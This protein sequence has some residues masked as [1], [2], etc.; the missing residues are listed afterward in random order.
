MTKMTKRQN[1]KRQKDKK[2]KTKSDKKRY[3]KTKMQN[4]SKRRKIGER[5]VTMSAAKILD[6]KRQKGK[7]SG[8][9]RGE[10]DRRQT[11]HDVCRL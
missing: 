6:I 3:E 10:Q 7:V 9:F 4:L 1:E 2:T 5:H 11:C 8:V